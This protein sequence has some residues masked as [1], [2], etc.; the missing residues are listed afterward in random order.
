MKREKEEMFIA[1]YPTGTVLFLNEV[2]KERKVAAPK[3]S[4]KSKSKKA[5]V[6]DVIR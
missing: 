3:D 6:L 5:R 4:A 1:V 2:L